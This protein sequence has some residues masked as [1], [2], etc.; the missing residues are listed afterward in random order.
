MLARQGAGAQLRAD[1]V[2]VS[3]NGGLDEAA[4]AVPGSPLPF[5]ATFLGDQ[6][7]VEVPR[8]LGSRVAVLGTAPARGGMTTSG[9]A[10]PMPRAWQMAPNNTI[11]LIQRLGYQIPAAV[12]R[13]LL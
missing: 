12:R 9:D 5:H 1:Q 6:P 8:G 7:D 10:A 11:W 2:F 3:L 4:P 13:A